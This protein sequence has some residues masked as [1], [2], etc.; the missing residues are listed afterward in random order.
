M[1]W[2][3]VVLRHYSGPI[4]ADLDRVYG[5]DLLD[6]WRGRIS[7]RALSV[8]VRYLP[9]ESALWQATASDLS[10]P[11]GNYLLAV[12]ANA[13][14][15]ANWQRAGGKGSQPKPVTLP[16]DA[17]KSS[18]AADRNAVMAERFLARQRAQETREETP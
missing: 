16:A 12:I 9:R 15:G 13:L 4:E 7:L 17:R 18:Q 8:R 11:D 10:W 14:H 5:I 6:F 2:L 3:A 1:T